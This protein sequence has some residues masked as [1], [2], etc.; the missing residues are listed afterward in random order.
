MRQFSFLWPLGR[1]AMPLVQRRTDLPF[2]SG[3]GDMYL[4]IHIF[5]VTR[6]GPPERAAASTHLVTCPSC[7]TARSTAPD[8]TSVAGGD[9]RCERCG[10]QW[11][12]SRLATVADYEAWKAVKTV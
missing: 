10:E 6:T 12:G 8:R 3:Y 2:A 5:P 1:I 4:T 7:H 11:T 9:W